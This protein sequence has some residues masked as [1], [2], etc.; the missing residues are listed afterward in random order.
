MKK[1]IAILL[2]MPALSPAQLTDQQRIDLY[3]MQE[4]AWVIEMR[5]RE[6]EYADEAE[7]ERLEENQ[8]EHQDRLNELIRN[9]Q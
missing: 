2:L 5:E 9:Q 8:R 7:R 4:H 6:K 3:E 1:L